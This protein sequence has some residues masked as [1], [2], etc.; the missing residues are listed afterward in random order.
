[1]H[2]WILYT[3]GIFTLIHQCSSYEDPTARILDVGAPWKPMQTLG[4]S[5]HYITIGALNP[6]N[7]FHLAHIAPHNAP[8]MQQVKGLNPPVTQYRNPFPVYDPIPQP[9]HHHHHFILPKENGQHI[10]P[11]ASN[12]AQTVVPN[13]YLKPAYITGKPAF[14]LKPEYITKPEFY[15]GIQ[16]TLVKNPQVPAFKQMPTMVKDAMVTLFHEAPSY[17]DLILTPPPPQFHSH[18]PL[19]AYKQPAPMKDK[20]VGSFSFPGDNQQKLNYNNVIPPQKEHFVKDEYSKNLVPP[21]YIHLE[22]STFRTTPFAPT[23]RPISLQE[24]A[25]ALNILNK[26][27]IPV[28]SP[29]QDANKFKYESIPRKPTIIPLNFSV[30][31]IVAFPTNAP[32]QTPLTVEPTGVVPSTHSFPNTKFH[33]QNSFDVKNNIQNFGQVPNEHSPPIPQKNVV[34]SEHT[35]FTISD[36]ITGRPLHQNPVQST[37]PP[38]RFQSS[39]QIQENPEV[40][41]NEEPNA[42]TTNPPRTIMQMGEY[43]TT[44]TPIPLPPVSPA[45]TESTSS[46]SPAEPFPSRT[47]SR[48]KNRRR[49]P[50]RP[51]TSKK[52]EQYLEEQ[53][54]IQALEQ[55]T[56]RERPSAP[57]S[58]T[59]RPFNRIRQGSRIRT[60]AKLSSTLPPADPTL[61]V[62][63]RNSL[64][65]RFNAI[66]ANMHNRQPTELYTTTSLEYHPPSLKTTQPTVEDIDTPEQDVFPSTTAL[67]NDDKTNPTVQIPDTTNLVLSPSEETTVPEINVVPIVAEATKLSTELSSVSS[68]VPQ[69]QE[70]TTEKVILN[71]TPKQPI[72]ETTIPAENIDPHL[73]HRQRYRYKVKPTPEATLNQE[74]APSQEP[75]EVEA[76][77]SLAPTP[78]T[79]S[80]RTVTRLRPVNK[81]RSQDRPRFSVKDYR[82]RIKT[83]STT[84]TTTTE[85]PSVSSS[86][87]SQRSR[88][89]F[90]TRKRLLP[91]LRMRSTT[92][93]QASDTE[94]DSQVDDNTRDNEQQP[95]IHSEVP[96]ASS[97]STT[98]ARPS[99]RGSNYRRAGNNR[100][101]QS[102]S[103]TESPETEEEV[104]R[105]PPARQWSRDR[106]TQRS[107]V[108]PSSTESL[109]ELQQI[110][111]NPEDLNNIAVDPVPVS[112]TA[113]AKPESAI[114]KISKTDHGNRQSAEVVDE[115]QSAPASGEKTDLNQSPSEQSERVAQLT[116]SGSSFKF[117]NPNKASISRRIPGYFT[118]ATEDPILPIEAFFPNVKPNSNRT[119]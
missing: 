66:S 63:Q 34:G 93:K 60:P 46:A 86:T 90:P 81:F 71:Q 47:R 104:E 117:N 52:P 70:L 20:P 111:M 58:T 114:M 21:P 112:S 84:T 54:A 51:T 35:Y 118:L 115:D 15:N 44:T 74:T 88:L 65:S 87:P 16:T 12:I 99:R 75:V 1:M 40:I 116:L 79:E 43:K 53:E 11:S 103:T 28:I 57:V 91:S 41:I 82:H 97:T 108:P 92:E 10:H 14:N 24:Q 83:H 59:D 96:S 73:S 18:S 69:I 29:L 68:P 26:Y 38:S 37:P 106:Y 109:T 9:H 4:V 77:S 31:S 67:S 78:E 95:S 7:N 56:V 6:Q 2:L 42:F 62:I 13:N 55:D 98:T 5:P 113:E 48:G 8:L 19:L 17:K 32:E 105:R 119:R 89:R 76:S 25:N 33:H 80:T 61:R 64:K 39:V 72:V 22:S 30:S 94:N 107:R 85:S 50:T 49:R 3:L 27:N 23:K 110:N 100:F 45:S 101:R 102:T 36:A